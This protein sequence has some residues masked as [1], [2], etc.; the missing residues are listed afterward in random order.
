VLSLLLILYA[1]AMF[2]NPAYVN[3]AHQCSFGVCW[4]NHWASATPKWCSFYYS[5]KLFLAIV[6]LTLLLCCCCN[7]C[8][9]CW[10]I[11]GTFVAADP[12]P[13]LLLH[14]HHCCRLPLSLDSYC[15]G[16]VAVAAALLLFL[17]LLLHC[18]CYCCCCCCAVAAALP[19]CAAVIITVAIFVAAA[20]LLLSLLL[21]CCFCP[22]C[23]AVV[24]VLSP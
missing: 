7:H 16:V 15:A 3:T 6:K 22:C 2:G 23:C 10:S 13:L 19:C 9:F 12:S 14:F 17:L 18:Y 4:G 11:G 21:R 8:C 5:Q 24:V 1:N 20:S